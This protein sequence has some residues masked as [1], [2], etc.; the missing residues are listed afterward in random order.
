MFGVVYDIVEHCEDSKDI[1][2]VSKT[3][4]DMKALNRGF[5]YKDFQGHLLRVLFSW[6]GF[7]KLDIKIDMASEVEMPELPWHNI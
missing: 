1:S 6:D 4:I 5:I 7:L 2:M 3:F